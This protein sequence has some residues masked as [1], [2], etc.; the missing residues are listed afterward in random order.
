MPFQNFS[1]PQVI[2]DLGLEL[3]DADLFGQIAENPVRPDFLALVLEGEDLASAIYTE[4]ARSE[5]VIAPI[6]FELRRQH[7]GKLGLFSGIELNAD[8]TR[9]LNGVCDFVITKSPGQ[10]VASAP[11]ITIVEAKNENL[12][13]GLGQC[14]AA[15]VAAQI[16]NRGPGAEGAVF[17][18]VT[19][20]GAWK[21][22]R[23]IGNEITLDLVEYRLESLPKILGILGH[24]VETA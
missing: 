15:M 4:K 21:F 5:F 18:T 12:R 22:L 8:A 17:G 13:S 6:L 16:L 3:G 10:H 11:L 19:S 14:I 1:F 9:G 20:G 23:L 7:K 2:R 24:I